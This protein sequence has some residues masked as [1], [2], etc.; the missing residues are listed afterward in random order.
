MPNPGSAFQEGFMVVD[1]GGLPRRRDEDIDHKGT[2]DTEKTNDV[3][4][5][6]VFVLSLS[7]CGLNP[8]RPLPPIQVLKEH[9]LDRLR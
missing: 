5:L 1:S 7:L 2:K 3:F 4:V 9:R 8:L 6:G